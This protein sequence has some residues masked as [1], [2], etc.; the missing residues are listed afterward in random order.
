[1]GKVIEAILGKL[2]EGSEM[3]A[4]LL[5]IVLA[6]KSGYRREATRSFK[7]G[8]RRFK[9]DWA[10]LYRERQKFYSLLNKLKREGLVVKKKKG[11]ESVW[12]I[13]SKGINELARQRGYKKQRGSAVV[14]VSYDIPEKLRT[15]RYWLRSCLLALDFSPLQK[16]V[17]IGNTELPEEFLRDLRTKNLIP[18]VHLFS[19]SKRGTI[20]HTA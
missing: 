5:T 11:N 14:I 6:G 20:E 12:N 2:Q 15:K 17:W 4:D 3:T 13:T 18:Y 1:M 19:V 10:A 8:P 7:Y 9:K 16:S